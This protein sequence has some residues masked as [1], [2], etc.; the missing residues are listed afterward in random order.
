MM[1][2]LGTT[3]PT[4]AQ[5]VVVGF[6]ERAPYI[7]NNADGRV[8]GKFGKKLQA[9][10]SAAQIRTRLKGIARPDPAVM[11]DNQEF[12]AFIVSKEIITTPEQF[13]FSEK[14][15]LIVKFYA[16]YLQGTPQINSIEGI[17]NSSVVMPLP[18]DK[19]AGDLTDWLR[20]P[21][22]NIK[23]VGSELDMETEIDM[24]QQGKAQYVVS[25]IDQN[26]RAMVFSPKAKS[27]KLQSSFIFEVP[28]YMV[29]RKSVHQSAEKIQRLDLSM[30]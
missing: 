7:Y 11:F 22:N 5:E 10:F 19:V 30:Q 13:L 4:A 8:K 14:P 25:Y 23:I 24:L 18:L 3:I 17:R 21:Q 9:Q 27:T 6:I 20:D 15:L 16:Y 1:G 26:S 28:M 12:D 29:L 2:L